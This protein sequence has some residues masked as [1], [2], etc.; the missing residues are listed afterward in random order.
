MALAGLAR[1]EQTNEETVPFAIVRRLVDGEVPVTVWREH[2]A[3]PVEQLAALA[4]VPAELSGGIEAG[5]EDIPLRVMHALAL[6]LRIDLDDLVPW[7]STVPPILPRWRRPADCLSCW[8][9]DHV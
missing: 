9:P 5:K 6:A 7:S 1:A 2:R 8:A 3:L 4:H